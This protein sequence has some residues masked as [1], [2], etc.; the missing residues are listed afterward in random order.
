[1]WPRKRIDIRF[2]DLAFGLF[3]CIAPGRDTAGRNKLETHFAGID[4]SLVCL[5]VRT[6]FDLLL[7]SL[8]L[9]KGS[10]VLMSAITVPDMIEIVRGHGLVP[11]PFDLEI[12]SLSSTP[13]AISQRINAKTKMIVLAHLFGVRM[14]LEALI[15]VARQNEILVIEDCAQAFDGQGFIG[16]QSTDVSLF[17]F[18][19]IK[20]ATALGGAMMRVNDKTLLC[21]IRRH[22]DRYPIQSKKAYAFRL[23][24]YA[25]LKLLSNPGSNI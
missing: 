24:K 17:S 19:P 18:G 16:T 21:Q 7:Q 4:H 13:E 10:E 22:H 3:R 11:V 12:E 20:S 9:P 14:P 25:A 5:S 1:M 23:A 8:N 15:R 2:G 6:G